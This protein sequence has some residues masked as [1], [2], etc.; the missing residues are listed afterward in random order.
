MCVWM[1]GVSR[2]VR[3]VRGVNNFWGFFGKFPRTPGKFPQLTG[4]YTGP[5]ERGIKNSH[6]S[7]FLSIF[8]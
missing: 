6:N 5:S 7:V 1:G 2:R 4:S 8:L 3:G